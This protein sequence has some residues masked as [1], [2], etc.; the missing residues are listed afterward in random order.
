MDGLRCG[1]PVPEDRK[2]V[3]AAPRQQAPWSAPLCL[4]RCKGRSDVSPLAS[5]TRL[6]GDASR[7]SSAA[8]AGSQDDQAKPKVK[9]DLKPMAGEQKLMMAATS[10]DYL[11]GQLLCGTAVGSIIMIS[12]KETTVTTLLLVHAAAVNSCAVS[13]TGQPYFMTASEDRTIRRWSM[14]DFQLEQSVSVGLRST[15]VAISPD[16]RLYAVGHRGG[17]FTV[18][19]APSPPQA[20]RCIVKNTQRTEDVTDIKFSPDGH[21]LAVSNREQ[22]IDIY[23]LMKD[24]RRIATC[25]GHSGAVLHIDFSAD[26][27]FLRSSCTA[28]EVLFWR[29]TTGKQVWCAAFILHRLP[30]R[31]FVLPALCRRDS[32]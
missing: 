14:I 22:S 7:P 3:T 1:D 2:P 9:V 31:L 17:K 23:D 29:S 32:L 4:R 24:F 5:V 18:W 30:L 19:D 21:L 8:R 25:I 26:G 15:A 16:D 20:P 28:G 11:D 27:R 6:A 12:V 13:P 10:I